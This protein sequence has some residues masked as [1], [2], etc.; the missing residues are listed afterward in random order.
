M[1]RRLSHAALVLLAALA[2]LLVPPLLVTML[3]RLLP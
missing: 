1:I 3:E 2:I